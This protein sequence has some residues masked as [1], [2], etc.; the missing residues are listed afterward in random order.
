MMYD[1]LVPIE[2][3]IQ[4]YVINAENKEQAI[5]KGKEIAIEMWKDSKGTI[6]PNLNIWEISKDDKQII[7]I[8]RGEIDD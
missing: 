6:I 2:G 7:A 4:V 1:V 5:I 8:R 3:Y